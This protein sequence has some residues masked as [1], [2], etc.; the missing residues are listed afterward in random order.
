MT[1]KSMPHLVQ[2]REVVYH[3]DQGVVHHDYVQQA[4][5]Y[6]LVVL[7]HLR[8]ADLCCGTL[9]YLS[10]RVYIH[11]MLLTDIINTSSFSVT[12]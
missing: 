9:L 12:T 10:N 2:N 1:Q 7:R 3:F 8:D 6:Y 11:Y 5:L 4:K